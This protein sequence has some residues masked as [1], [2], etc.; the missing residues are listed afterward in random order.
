MK[1][2]EK[3]FGEIYLIFI[4]DF[5]TIEKMAEYYRVNKELLTHWIDCGRTARQ[6]KRFI[7]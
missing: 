6:N 1:L 7:F 4:N 3:T 5:L 2:E